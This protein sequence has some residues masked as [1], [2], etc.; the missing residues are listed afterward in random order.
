M[1]GPE[2]P[3][4]LQDLLLR[5]AGV[6]P[7]SFGNEAIVGARPC[8]SSCSTAIP[9]TRPALVGGQ[10]GQCGAIHGSG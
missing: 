10:A 9:N 3:S 6:E 7:T 8:R 4:A 2:V 1:R 5:E